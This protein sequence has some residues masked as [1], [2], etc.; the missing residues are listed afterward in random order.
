MS[1]PK[2]RFILL[3]LLLSLPSSVMGMAIVIKL[4]EVRSVSGWSLRPHLSS[5]Q[6]LW[7]V[8]KMEKMEKPMFQPRSACLQHIIGP[9]DSVSPPESRW[10]PEGTCP[11][12]PTSTSGTPALLLPTWWRKT[13]TSSPREERGGTAVHSTEFRHSWVYMWACH[14]QPRV[15]GG[16]DSG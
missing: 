12:V 6:G 14:S 5:G 11:F 8:Q 2:I 7:K 4:Q 10:S 13:A 15:H 3:L 9:K 16:R 1:G